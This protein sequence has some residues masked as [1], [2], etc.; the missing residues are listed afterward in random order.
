MPSRLLIF[1][2]LHNTRDLGGMRVPDGRSIR[3]GLL[4]RS[5][6][7]ADLSEGDVARLSPIART[8]VDFRTQDERREQPDREIPGAGNVHIPIV[9]SLTAGISREALADLELFSLFLSKPAQARD[10]MCGMYGLLA[11]DFSAKQYGRFLQIL[12][13]AEGGVLWHCTAGKDRAGIASAIVEEILG[14]PREDIVADYL[15]TNECL[16]RDIRSLT[17]LVKKMNGMDSPPADVAPGYLPSRGR[18]PEPAG[19]SDSPTADVAL[20]YLLGA[21]EE[22]IRSFYKAVDDKYGSF[23]GFVRDALGLDDAARAAFRDKYLTPADRHA[24]LPGSTAG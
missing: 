16:R 17:D 9:E 21:K 24:G 18:L 22:Y 2:K 6:H 11:E 12:L 23:D 3:P 1:D 7:L 8:I 14:V 13:D 20:G 19:S 4:I 15:M 10:Y 5:G